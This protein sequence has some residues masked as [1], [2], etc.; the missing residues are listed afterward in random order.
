MGA[1]DRHAPAIRAVRGLLAAHG[2]P[3]DRL[4]WW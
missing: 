1:L 4:E 3:S 2:L